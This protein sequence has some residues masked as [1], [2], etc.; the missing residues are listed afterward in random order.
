MAHKFHKLKTDSAF[1]YLDNQNVYQYDNDFDYSRYDYTQM[2][3]T[4]CTVPWDMGEAHIGNR[5]ISGIGNVVYFETKEKRD[6]WFAAIPDSECFRFETKYKELHRNQTL[7]VPIPFDVA[8]K[9]NYVVVEYS[10]FANDES[11]VMYEH[12]G[13]MRQWFWFIREVEFIAPNNTRLHI[14]D[15]AFQTWIYDV[16]ISGMVLERGHA[17]MFSMKT[18]AYLSNPLENNTLLLTED[19]NFGQIEQVKHIDA[20]ALNAGDMYACIA[21][22]ANPLASWGT[23]SGDNWHTP[24]SAYYMN[25]G[26]P[27]VF[28]FA[29]E[30]SDLD[31]LLTNIT[32]SYPQ[33]KQT[34]QSVFFASADLITIGS[35]FTFADITC[36]RVSA[37]RKTFNLCELEKSLF[38]YDAKYR[39]I[40]KLYTSPYAHIEIT[41]ENGNVDIVRIEDT[42]GDINVSV[43]L[44]IAYPFINI[45]S[46]L[47]GVGGNASASVTYRNVSS[48]TFPIS[49]QWY[50]T[51][52][53]WKVPTFAIVLDAAR[54][55]D[56]STHFDRVQRVVDYTTAY[57]NAAASATTDKTNNDALADAT[58][59]N[60][61]TIAAANK[62]NADDLADNDHTNTYNNAD[63]IDDNSLVTQ[64]ANTAITN[65][66]NTSAN[67]ELGYTQTYNSG[68]AAADTL[69]TDL[70]ASSTIA[71]QEQQAT[72][73]A[74]SGAA[75][76]VVGMIASA[77]SGDIAGAVTGGLNAA[78]GAATTL[79]SSNVAVQ[80][81]AASANYTNAGTRAHATAANSNSSSK[82]QNQTDTATDITNLQNTQV[83]G[84]ATNNSGTM[85][86]NA[87]NTQTAVKGNASRTETAENTAA[88]N[89]QTT[90]KDNNTLIYNTA[91]ANAGRSRTQAQSAIIND[92]AQAA[93]RAPFVYGSFADGDNAT[94]K[95][96]ALFANI[97]TQSKSAISSA[98]DEFLRYGYAL[99]KQWNF[100]GNWNIGKYFTYWKLR[101]FW[102]SNL[103]VPDMYID[104]L[105]FFLYG[106]VT[107]WR[108]PEDIGKVTVYENFNG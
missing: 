92:I 67:N 97:V 93:L 76:G 2:K 27:S 72:I 99:D 100:N 16:N 103:N 13:G 6:A 7:D 4:L 82:T 75:S 43:A 48:K 10:L 26:V 56:Y 74:A 54:E 66:S 87:D 85:R 81:T 80:L 39:D 73:A 21:T 17:P 23:K 102:V 51:L 28:V 45:E 96:I 18:D 24:A 55:Y 70:S 63:N 106:G 41:D 68:I 33:F 79:A 65:R 20:L 47:L 101:D 42:T 14:L 19:V 61:A 11:P 5:T 71:A 77:A 1:P 50:E 59:A 12:E 34:V 3:I 86:T 84:I 15:D 89:T 36:Y 69:L 94:T 58:A 83:D 38:G 8:A 22:T 95:P 44:S 29:V 53:S 37:S 107:I 25:D 30:V 35:E 62:D 46:H 49:G 57:D 104:K 91:I 40:A 60:V 78:I 9:F 105:R 52:R 32:A 90:V 98:G 64:T 31:N 108:N 88:Q